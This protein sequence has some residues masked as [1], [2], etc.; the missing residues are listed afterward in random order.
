MFGQCN[1]GETPLYLTIQTD[2]WGYETYWQITP[3]GS[4]CGEQMIAEGGNLVQV[5]CN[6]GGDQD[7]TTAQGYE[8]QSAIEEGP[9]CLTI[10]AS[11]TLHYVDGLS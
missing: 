5:G 1:E 11:Y 7:A 10:G 8:N 2:N 4:A 3:E 6:G 9:I